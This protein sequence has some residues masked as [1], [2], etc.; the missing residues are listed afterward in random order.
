MRYIL[1]SHGEGA[2]PA[3]F[4]ICDTAAERELAT[5]R[6][7]YG[8]AE[9]DAECWAKEL[10]E[11]RDDGWLRFEGDAPIQWVDAVG[12]EDRRYDVARKLVALAR[13]AHN[14][15]DNSEAGAN[16]D[17]IHVPEDDF[18]SL[19]DALDA[20]DAL[21]ELPPPYVGT[22]PAKAEYLLGLADLH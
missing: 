3:K 15:A 12:P 1:I 22:G 7:I 13:A 5:Q 18:Q 11:L 2:D 6:A 8:T 9:V 19:S 16:G 17:Q 10:A 21:P 4:V 14:L 20:L